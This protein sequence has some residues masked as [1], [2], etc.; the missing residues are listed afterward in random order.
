MTGP[1]I[2]LGALLEEILLPDALGEAAGRLG[3]RGRVWFR[4]GSGVRRLVSQGP[5]DGLDWQSVPRVV[6]PVVRDGGDP[7]RSPLQRLAELLLAG[8]EGGED[9]GELPP[10]WEPLL[11]VA[12][13]ASNTITLSWIQTSDSSASGS[14]PASRTP[15]SGEH[16]PYRALIAGR[17]ERFLRE[18]GAY[19]QWVIHRPCLHLAFVGAIPPLELADA[20]ARTLRQLGM[21][22]P[23]FQ[24]RW[25]SAP[26][27]DPE[28][29]EGA[30]ERFFRD[31]LLFHLP[32]EIWPE[33]RGP[34]EESERSE[35]VGRI[36]AVE[37]AVERIVDLERRSRE[38]APLEFASALREIR[39]RL[40]PVGE[41]RKPARGRPE[42][43]TTAASSARR[44]LRES[45]RSLLLNLS[46]EVRHWRECPIEVPLAP[47]SLLV[48][49]NASGKTALA[50]SLAFAYS[51][52]PRPR[53]H[54]PRGAWV[55]RSQERDGRT[56]EASASAALS[57][58]NLLL[59]RLRGALAEGGAERIE[60]LRGDQVLP[61]RDLL[62]LF[63]DDADLEAGEPG[64]LAVVTW[65]PFPGLRGEAAALP[66]SSSSLGS[67]LARAFF[68]LDQI[69]EA[70]QRGG[71][72]HRPR[73]P[74]AALVT[75]QS[76]I[77]EA[78]RSLLANRIEDAGGRLDEEKRR[79]RLR[80]RGIERRQQALEA[81]KEEHRALDRATSSLTVPADLLR[82][83]LQELLE[84]IEVRGDV[85]RRDNPWQ[86][87]IVFSEALGHPAP[88]QALGERHLLGEWR[89]V[90]ERLTGLS[91]SLAGLIFRDETGFEDQMRRYLSP[92]L[93]ARMQDAVRPNTASLVRLGQASRVARWL[94]CSSLDW[95][96]LVV[97]E[98]AM[99]QDEPSC[100]RALV[101]LIRL[102]RKVE[103]Q[104]WAAALT[105][106]TEAERRLR[107]ESITVENL[108]EW[109]HIRAVGN[110][111]M[112]LRFRCS[113]VE[114]DLGRLPMP[115][116]ILALSYREAALSTV[117]D[118]EGVVLDYTLRRRLEN[119]VPRAWWR[120][121]TVSLESARHQILEDLTP[122]PDGRPRPVPP[123]LLR[124]YWQP[125]L[126]DLVQ[127]AVSVRWK[128]WRKCAQESLE[129]L[130]LNGLAEDIQR[131]ADDE[132]GAATLE[133]A[134]RLLL[135]L[136]VLDLL[137][138]A[139]ADGESCFDLS[140]VSFRE[141]TRTGGTAA[142]KGPTRLRRVVPFADALP[143]LPAAWQRALSAAPV[144][145]EARVS[146]DAVGPDRRVASGGGPWQVAIR[147][148]SSVVD[149][150]QLRALRQAVAEI[151]LDPE[152]GRGAPDA[153][154]EL[155]AET[156]DPW[157]VRRWA[158]LSR[159]DAEPVRTQPMEV[160]KGEPWTHSWP[161]IT[162]ELL[163]QRALEL[164]QTLSPGERVNLVLTSYEPRLRPVERIDFRFAADPRA[165]SPEFG[166]IS[167]L[168]GWE[169]TF[170]AGATRVRDALL[171]HVG[172]QRIAVYPRCTPG[173]ALRVGAVF[174]RASRVHVVC[175]Q[176]DR[177][178]DLDVPLS[179]QRGARVEVREVSDEP[180][181]LHL[182]VAVAR[183]VF[184]AYSGW[185][186][187]SGEMPARV[188]EIQPE[189]G[190]SAQAIEGAAHAVGIAE[191][192]HTAAIQERGTTSAPIRFFIAAP[193]ALC[194]AIGR[195]LN[196][197]GE[198][199]AMD[200]G[201]GPGRYFEAFRF[202]T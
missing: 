133:T 184:D 129:A 91:K 13:P 6:P 119:L 188:V 199:I 186:Q 63:A 19:E 4:L 153:T 69:R 122:T 178:W 9:W 150:D 109:P 102:S 143:P 93:D 80:R 44:T 155:Q 7:R 60:S 103:S 142:E 75:L 37:E 90:E 165:D 15:Q 105:E 148:D 192:V 62:P 73:R 200:Y 152:E 163:R 20:G 2:D 117:S 187:R 85:G 106:E 26:P 11:A 82:K 113:T 30:L 141:L 83:H 160:A 64:D 201:S 118:L 124:L 114:G 196:K 88:L 98:P 22:L 5:S 134:L 70:I 149:P 53:R 79:N 51:G 136:V 1:A 65:L 123:A 78:F 77:F 138:A 158:E 183:P 49:N 97:D 128:E 125:P 87:L 164:D 43:G 92:S 120:A 46:L 72:P 169:R 127:F 197:M 27:K 25:V 54:A 176:N 185:R 84:E 24:L 21:Y 68:G 14:S 48:G 175:E 194:L 33:P 16:S 159:P 139:L 115:P 58:P 41:E 111:G 40:P 76:W 52:L 154:I 137:P 42:Q 66:S 171:T 104:R 145:A 95:P 166:D 161:E 132:G 45:S 180:G 31:L 181:E 8:E 107:L 55:W 193:V 108:Q 146:P 173:T 174:H 71:R 59:H 50:E 18:A 36:G 74:S 39:N 195:R 190:P 57:S 189:R 3:P 151:G 147:S 12:D 94:A 130:G 131:E 179:E 167:N 28:D 168:L 86:N 156:I 170:G 23:D 140:G 116:Q 56:D 191:A 10:G 35:I 17:V 121:L 135:W 96:F 100:A 29:P 89:F 126:T 177:L 101:R 172:T 162:S 110:P 34:F 32:W 198:I 81:A 112:S 202:H 157:T 61:S 99:G 144:P 47:T 182:L 67:G 38:L